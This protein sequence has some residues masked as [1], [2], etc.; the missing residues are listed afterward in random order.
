[1]SDAAALAEFAERTFLDAFGP[2]NDPEHLKAY[3]PAAYGVAHQT[4]ELEDPGVVYLLAH[5][6]DTLVGYAMVRRGKPAEC[7]THEKPVELHR[8]YVDRPAHGTGVAQRLMAAARDTAR[9]LGARHLWLGVWEKNARGI[10]FY[11]KEGFVNV[12][13]HD[14]YVGPDRQTDR[15]FV[16]RL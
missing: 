6:G 1:M 5:N 7:V 11:I 2:A 8:F 16:V 10:A 4:R 15:V 12:G 13:S 14:F 3:L 9:E